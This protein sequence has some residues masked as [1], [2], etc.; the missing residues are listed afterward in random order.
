[1]TTRSIPM[2]L[3]SAAIIAAGCGAD[4]EASKPAPSASNAAAKTATLPYG[5]YERRVT[6]ADV[7]RTATKRD[8]HGPHQETPGTGRYRLVIAQG[9]KQDVVKAIGPDGFP[10]AMDAKSEPDQVL[11]M[12]SYVNPAEGAFCGPEVPAS[13]RYRFSADG[14]T[15]TLE[16][17]RPDQ[18]A[19]R[20]TV[21]TGSWTKR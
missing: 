13:G 14:G 18:C 12:P 15:L 20:D 21:L 4:D 8:E 7:K 10:I 9:P 16:P 5:T 11:A 1:M 2:L 17:S 19:D 3:A 6:A